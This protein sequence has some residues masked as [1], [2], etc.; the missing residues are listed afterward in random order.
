MRNR[1][2]WIVPTVFLLVSLGVNV[3]LVQALTE[4]RGES[5]ELLD[6]ADSFDPESVINQIADVGAL[7]LFVGDGELAPH[8]LPCSGQSVTAKDHSELHAALSARREQ[9]GGSTGKSAEFRLPNLSGLFLPDW[10]RVLREIESEGV[11]DQLVLSL[12]ARDF[13]HHVAGLGPTE[14]AEELAE[15]GDGGISLRPIRLA[16]RAR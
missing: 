5:I 15:S 7:G 14:F 12:L 4:E 9:L 16:V 11:A 8:W 10:E 3:F 13:R 6:P 1:W 2:K